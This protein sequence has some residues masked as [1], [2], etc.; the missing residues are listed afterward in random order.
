MVLSAALHSLPVTLVP[1]RPVHAKLWFAWRNEPMARRYMPLEPWSVT[2]LRKR[3]AASKPDLS[4][5][6]KQEHRWVVVFQEQPVGL[7]SLL[8]PSFRL[9]NAEVSYHLGEAFHRRGIATCALS[10]LFDE[11]FERTALVRL[12]AYIS[13]GNRGSRRLA[14]KLG[15]VHEGTLREHFPI[16]GK[17]V[18]QCLYG[19]LRRDWAKTKRRV[20][21]P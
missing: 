12:F 6:E 1:P 7:V 10:A 14:E 11:V 19:L 9:G 5:P 3:L 4:D 2:A 15:F 8:R 21:I 18:N 17:R 20:A 13:E 16:D